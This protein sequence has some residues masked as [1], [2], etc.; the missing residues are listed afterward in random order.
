VVLGGG[1][2]GL[3]TAKA[4]DDIADVTLVDPSDAFLH[5][6]ASWRALVE[7]HWIEQIFMPLD[8]LLH[9]IG[10]RTVLGSPLRALPDAEPGVL[11]PV[12]VTTESGEVV[13]ADI[14]FRAFGVRPATDYVRGALAAALNSSGYLEVDDRLRV[15]GNDGVYAIGDIGPEAGASQFP[16]GVTGPEATISVKG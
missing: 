10:V 6:V 8:R 9:E 3:R 15:K 11:A 12:E 7:P 4:L 13:T 16:D 5:N 14:W 2:G 1:Y